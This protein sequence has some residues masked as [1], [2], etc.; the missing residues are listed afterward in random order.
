MEVLEEVQQRVM[1]L[2]KGL[3]HLCYEQ[4]LRELDLVS[5]EKRRPR[6]ISLV[7]KHLKGRC[8]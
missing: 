6:K 5:L 7:N 1:K 3:E 2:V 4:R 8:T